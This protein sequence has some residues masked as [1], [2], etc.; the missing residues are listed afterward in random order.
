MSED[1]SY[2]QGYDLDDRGMKRRIIAVILAV[3]VAA[4]VAMATH[5][6][7]VGPFGARLLLYGEADLYVLN[8]SDR[9]QWVSIDGGE[10]QRVQPEGARLLRL[11]GGESAIEIYDDGETE[12]P[13][14]TLLIEAKHSDALLNLS[15]HTC[16]VVATVEGL[17]E[18]EI[19]LEVVDFLEADVKTYQLGSTNVIWPR[20]YPGVAAKKEGPPMAVEL[21]DCTLVED[22]DFVEDYLAA[23][24]AQRLE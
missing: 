12:S 6:A 2:E 19:T 18:G 5:S 10:R 15:D 7:G 13:V 8:V 24:L 23:R 14:E 3:L 17:Q 21:L 16:L 1:R 4:V 20:G 11:V 9:P 22:R